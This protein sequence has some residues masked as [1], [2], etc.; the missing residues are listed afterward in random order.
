MV[1]KLFESS[2][3]G[4]RALSLKVQVGVD[5]GLCKFKPKFRPRVVRTLLEVIQASQV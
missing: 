5:S 2:G 1:I 4:L 3:L